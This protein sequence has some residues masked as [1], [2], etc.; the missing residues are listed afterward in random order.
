MCA[1]HLLK[2]RPRRGP[3]GSAKSLSRSSKRN[4]SWTGC[5]LPAAT[6]QGLSSLSC[7]SERRS[8]RLIYFVL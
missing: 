4:A 6:V 7:G 1:A 5:A 8:G 2:Y 3:G